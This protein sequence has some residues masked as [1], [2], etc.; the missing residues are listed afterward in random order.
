MLAVGL[1]LLYF[2]WFSGYEPD[3][4][5]LRFLSL[6][7]ICV[8]VFLYFGGAMV[9]ITVISEGDPMLMLKVNSAGVTWRNLHRPFFKY[10]PWREIESVEI[11]SS[12]QLQF[13]SFQLTNKSLVDRV[14]GGP[15]V[16]PAFVNN[17]ID[18][19]AK[20]M[21]AI[22]EFKQRWKEPFT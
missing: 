14:L 20:Q 15:S 13:I 5:L 2:S 10:I 4:N 9:L 21:C 18:A 22:P 19:A 6:K 7:Y 3:R 1:G 11:K 8:P 17:D 12:L 16:H